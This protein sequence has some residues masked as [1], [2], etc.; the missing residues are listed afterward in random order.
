MKKYTLVVIACLTLG[1]APFFPEP[2]IIG[3][4]RWIFGGAHVMAPIDWWDT[5]QHGAPWLVLLYFLLRDL[6]EKFKSADA[7]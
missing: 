4:V 7:K 1:L 6:V 5:L 3:K 2:H